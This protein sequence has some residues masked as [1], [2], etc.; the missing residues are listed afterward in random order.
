VTVLAVLADVHR[1]V[2][3]GVAQWRAADPTGRFCVLASYPCALMSLALCWEA[4]SWVEAGYGAA[5][6]CLGAA[7]FGYGLVRLAPKRGFTDER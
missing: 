7:L 2:V 4:A 1:G 5:V 6:G 3:C